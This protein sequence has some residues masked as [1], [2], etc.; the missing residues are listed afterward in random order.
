MIRFLT[1]AAS[2]ID[3]WLHK[4]LGRPYGV[5]LSIGLVADI[6]HR[7]LDAPRHVRER[8]HLIGMVLVVTMELALLLHQL[9]EMHERLGDRSH[10]A[11]NRPTPEA[12]ES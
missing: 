2:R 3:G 5:M 7:L 11:G 4:R 10:D 12:A 1:G 6:G 9:A 8:H